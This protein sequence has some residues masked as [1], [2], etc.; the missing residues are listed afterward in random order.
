MLQSSC[1][2]KLIKTLTSSEGKTD[3][4]NKQNFSQTSVLIFKWQNENTKFI[5]ELSNSQME[6]KAVMRKSGE[7]RR[8]IKK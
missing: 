1:S 4:K 6:K 2:T 5:R 7:F 3:C 8:K